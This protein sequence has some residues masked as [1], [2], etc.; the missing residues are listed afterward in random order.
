MSRTT[1]SSGTALTAE[2]KEHLDQLCQPRTAAMRDVQRAQILW[3]YQTGETVTQIA[4]ALKTKA[5]QRRLAGAW[6]GQVPMNK[7]RLMGT[8][9]LQ[10]VG[11]RFEGVEF[12][13]KFEIFRFLGARFDD[14]G[15]QRAGSQALR[16]GI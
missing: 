15:G 9:S 2:D 8:F 7:A 3:R 10:Y 16:R 12:F 14:G 13:E 1:A 11:C 4:R 6:V 5:Q